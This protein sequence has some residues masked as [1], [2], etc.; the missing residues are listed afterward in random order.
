MM[1][2]RQTQERA[3]RKMEQIIRDAV[4][5]IRGLFE[6]NAD[7]HGFDHSCRVWSSA[8]MIAETEPACDPEIVALAALLHDADDH[9]L[10]AT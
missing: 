6:G 5:Y 3:D 4:E 10:F 1:V 8:M 9:K 2:R 7:G